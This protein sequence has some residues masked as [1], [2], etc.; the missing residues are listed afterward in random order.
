MARGVPGH[1][2]AMNEPSSSRL[3][4]S[5]GKAKCIEVVD[6]TTGPASSLGSGTVVN[7]DEEFARMLQAQYDDEDE[8]EP[9][10]L[11]SAF[12]NDNIDSGTAIESSGG[13]LDDERF[14]RELQDEL[15]RADILRIGEDEGVPNG[16]QATF[17]GASSASAEYPNLSTNN[18]INS[19]HPDGDARAQDEAFARQ[20]QA[21]YDGEHSPEALP[22]PDLSNDGASTMDPL[23]RRGLV[24]RFAEAVRHTTCASCGKPS[25]SSEKELV[26]KFKQ[27][28]ELTSNEKSITDVSSILR[29]SKA[30]CSAETCLGCGV[31]SKGR[32]TSSS[33]A[34]NDSYTLTWCCARGRMA[35]IWILLCGYDRRRTAERRRDS[36]FTKPTTSSSKG[37]NGAGVGYDSGH[38]HNSFMQMAQPFNYGS[39]YGMYAPPPSYEQALNYGKYGMYT[40]GDGY[41]QPVNYSQYGAYQPPQPINHGKDGM[42]QP[43][44][45]YAPSRY[46]Q[47]VNNPAASNTEAADDEITACLMA[48]LD[49]LLPSLVNESVQDFD[50]EP[51]LVL[52]AILTQ[53]NFLGTIAALLRNDSLEDATKRTRLYKTTL[54][55]VN[56]LGSHHATA[57]P[58]IHHARQVQQGGPDIL[59]LSF[60]PSHTN[61]QDIKFEEAQSLAS[62]LRNFH[63]QSK[64]MLVNAKAHPQAFAG[65]DSE[66]MLSLCRGVSDLA[67][68]LLANA[69][70]VAAP[71][72]NSGGSGQAPPCANDDWQTDLAVLELPDEEIMSRHSYGQVARSAHNLAPGRM[73]SL[74]L[75][76]SNLMTSLPPGIF[77]RHCASRLDVMKVLIIGPKGT[78]YEHGLFEFDLFCPSNFPNAPPNM[79]FRTTGGGRVRFNP[80]LYN[81]GK[82]CLSLLGT[83]QGET[84]QPGKST[85]LQVLVSIQAMI[86]CDEP[87]YNEPGR[88]ANPIASMRHNQELQGYTVRHA[89]LDWLGPELDPVWGDVV[90]R[91]FV[92]RAREIEGVVSGWGVHQGT[93]MQL[94]GAIEG[95]QS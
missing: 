17:I 73:K 72:A 42:S 50:L 46:A 35:I 45:K 58:T 1:L 2:G 30:T 87:W 78:P 56:K 12:P 24:Q 13:L 11:P 69:A 91:H 28:F 44:G 66:Q 48:C 32:G 49:V 38:G 82:V 55:V 71:A 33:V 70:P 81:C 37:S 43:L 68:F 84:W 83:W 51:P 93:R 92:T 36:Y 47:P 79:L 8:Y 94:M 64:N 90:E 67:D 16:R 57:G 26:L 19:S 75:Q 31:Q 9:S 7:D 39:N 86:F 22:I 25:L 40:F 27:W 60:A 63:K 41:P 18:E 89:M 21:Q 95:L 4:A 14:A 15:D 29:C 20:L 6:L 23:A 88:S 59:S 77:I 76:L 54:D 61:G 52:A 74:S 5:A 62:C 80:N 34:L 3:S 53:S 65:P 85:I 10:P